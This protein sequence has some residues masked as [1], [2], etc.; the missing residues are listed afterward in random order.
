[1]PV[2]FDSSAKGSLLVGG[3]TA[4]NDVTFNHNVSTLAK[5][6][7]VAF[8]AVLWTGEADTTGAT[9]AVTF[10]GE[11][12]TEIGDETWDSDKATL[13]LFS[14]EDAPR[15]SQEVVATF[16]TMPTE[17]I[18]RNFMVESV[19]Y[20]GVDTIGTAVSDGADAGTANTVEVTSVLPAHRVLAA[21]GV[22][23]LRGFTSSG[24]NQ[25]KR[26]SV[27]MFGGGALLVGDAPGADTVTSTATHNASTDEWGAIGVT[28]TP[29]IVELTASMTVHLSTR[30]ALGVYRT[31]SAHP[32]RT[33][34]IP[35]VG[36]ADP[37]LLAGNFIVSSDGVAMPVF[38][39]DTDDTLEYTL[40]W[41]NHL[42]DDDE[43]VFVE[44]LPSGTLTVFSESFDGD[45]TQV[46]LSGGTATVTHP[47][48][49][50][51]V[52]KKGRQHDRTFYI[53][54]STL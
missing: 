51:A 10:G 4:T 44:H 29:A 3:A 20:S 21:H 48:R 46:W 5:D 39:K 45:T 6:M 27:T 36:S 35:A 28:M 12:M 50:R 30:A 23:K 16:A 13:R 47:V 25:T 11:T 7:V 19:T 8:V 22:G 18:T 2:L 52:T 54:G 14:L 40:H 34:T 32:D 31:S 49:I 43:I 17:L 1:M 24:Y 41:I 26:N 38:V 33:Y 9:F 37:N 15:G 42:V 53:A